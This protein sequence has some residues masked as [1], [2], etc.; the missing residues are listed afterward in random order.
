MTTPPLIVGC[1]IAIIYAILPF[2]IFLTPAGVGF[3]AD[4]L[5]N[6]TRVLML[7][8]IGSAIFHTALLFIPTVT[9]T[10]FD[11]VQNSRYGHYQIFYSVC[12]FSTTAI[13]KVSLRL[14][15]LD[16]VCYLKA[17]NGV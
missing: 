16:K 9:R 14:E 6:F 2:T 17:L 1:Q 12:F 7:T 8:V 11:S 4:K 13:V 10:H 15:K 5:G 3:L